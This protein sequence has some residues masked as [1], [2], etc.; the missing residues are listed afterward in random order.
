MTMKV[1]SD[2]IFWGVLL[3]LLGLLALAQQEGW[4]GVF[5][6]QFWMLAFGALSLIFFV[7]YLL[8]GLRRWGW[9]FPACIFAAVSVTMW[10]FENGVQEAWM[11]VPIFIA[12]IIPFLVA[13]FLNV[14]ENWWAL[15]PS[16]VLGVVCLVVF[17]EAQ[18]P[19]ELI[20][21][22]IMFSVAVPFLVVY[23]SNREK[24][25]ALIPAFTTGMI[26][27]IILLSMYTVRWIGALV[28]L[29]IA[30]PFFYV[31]FT[32]S[33]SWWALIPAGIM[34]S[35]GL[36][37]L[38]TDPALGRFADSSFPAAVLFGGWAAT[39]Y[40]LWREREKFPTS[41]ARIPALVMGI[42]AIILLVT[43]SLTDLGLVV[44][45]IVAGLVLIFHGL[46]PRKE[47]AHQSDN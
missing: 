3:V 13:F 22:L 21:A 26:G 41:W 14:R 11:A 24:R 16:F 12:I 10:L 44:V 20:G 43:G 45:L 23:L 4:I 42:L 15:I 17:F 40:W 8:A 39:F 38:L 2:N 32:H 33:Q 35:I 27:V 34:G 19:G 18:V 30:I 47:N 25:W 7:R 1:K 36:N 31:Y 29:A 6:T 46:R 5:S 28:P 37:V 9:L